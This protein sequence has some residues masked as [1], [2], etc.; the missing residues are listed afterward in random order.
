MQ[1]GEWD[2]SFQV[3]GVL[4]PTPRTLH[5]V[6]A[7]LC[8]FAWAL[9]A[10]RPY[11]PP[12][13]HR[14]KNV[15]VAENYGARGQPLKLGQVG[16]WPCWGFISVGSRARLLAIFKKIPSPTPRGLPASEIKTPLR[17]DRPTLPHLINSSTFSKRSEETLNNFG[18]LLFAALLKF[19]RPGITKPAYLLERGDRGRTSSN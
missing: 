13:M 2:P 7:L 18:R 10:P 3:N 17:W 8:Q 9:Q 5:S 11:S 1:L 6:E 15:G 14:H 4:Y 12:S 19:L 16:S